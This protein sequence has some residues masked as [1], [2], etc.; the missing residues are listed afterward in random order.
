MGRPYIYRV[1]SLG[2]QARGVGWEKRKK[3]RVA[4]GFD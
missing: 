3:K 2:K 1:K 4:L